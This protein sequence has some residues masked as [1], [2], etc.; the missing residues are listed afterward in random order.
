MAPAH[1]ASGTY[2]AIFKTNGKQICLGL[3]TTDSEIAAV[4]NGLTLSPGHRLED[5]VC[6]QAKALRNYARWVDQADGVEVW[7]PENQ[8]GNHC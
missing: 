1:R 7:L 3:K 2:Y 5:K 8:L 4:A 6:P